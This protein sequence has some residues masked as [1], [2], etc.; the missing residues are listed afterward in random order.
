MWCTDCQQDVPAV[1]RSANEVPVCP[2][3]ERRLQQPSATVPSDAGIALD[4][5]DPPPHQELTSPVDWV[6]QE[7]IRQRLR[8]IDHQ[9]NTSVDQPMSASR[10]PAWSQ[11]SAPPRMSEAA[12]LRAVAR[13]AVVDSTAAGESRNRTSWLLSLLLSLGVVAFGFGLGL[14]GWSAAFQLPELW[15]HGMT[16]TIGAEG[17]LI[18]SLTWMAARLWRNGRRVNRQLHGVDRQLA[19]IEQIT[20]ALAGSGQA[21]SQHYY[22]HFSQV[23]S[24][25]LLMAN[26]QGQMD[27]LAARLQ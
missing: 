20:G 19:E 21:S 24:P 3:C 4:S 17:L 14:L 15:Q 10:P 8:E 18:L 22:H 11:L 16:L 13:R 25:H 6:E 23:A 12:P 27:Q 26:L 1:A 7:R 5:F 9:L 2:R